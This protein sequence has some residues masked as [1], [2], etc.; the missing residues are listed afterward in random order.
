[1]LSLKKANG[2][3]SI[4]FYNP[5]EAIKLLLIVISQH[6]HQ[7]EGI[8]DGA[9]SFPLNQNFSFATR[10]MLRLSHARNQ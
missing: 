10:L 1:M 7:Q 8:P 6:P 9:A 5:E 3:L 4:V 2:R